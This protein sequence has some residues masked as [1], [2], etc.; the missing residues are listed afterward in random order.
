MR[1]NHRVPGEPVRGTTKHNRGG[2]LIGG[3]QVEEQSMARSQ[4]IALPTV[5]HD[6][7]P[8]D[9]SYPPSAPFNPASFTRHFLG[10][11][12]SDDWPMVEPSSFTSAPSSSFTRHFLGSNA[13][14]LF[15]R[16][17]ELVRF[18]PSTLISQLILPVPQ[19]HLLWPPPQR[20]PRSS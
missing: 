14:S 3:A 6:D 16:E 4:P 8:I 1:A 12:V 5:Q 13:R 18:F 11:P 15:D 10:S 2:T 7:W 19:L 9:A 17:G 20:P